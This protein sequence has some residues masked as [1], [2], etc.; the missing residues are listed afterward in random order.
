MSDLQ[1]LVLYRRFCHS[2]SNYTIPPVCPALRQTPATRPDPETYHKNASS[3][4]SHTRAARTSSRS[5][6]YPPF[7][8]PPEVPPGQASYNRYRDDNLNY[9]IALSD[10]RHN[11]INSH[12]LP[13][14]QGTGRW[15]AWSLLLRCGV[16]SVQS[17]VMQQPSVIQRFIYGIS[18]PPDRGGN[19]GQG[20]IHHLRSPAQGHETS[21][22]PCA[23]G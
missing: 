5:L 10:S 16:I 18:Y 6:S 7:C 22:V 19:E 2:L 23:A 12:K 15:E 14:P 17:S 20:N 4:Y 3:R 1:E 8:K 21:V 9:D 11:R 13:S